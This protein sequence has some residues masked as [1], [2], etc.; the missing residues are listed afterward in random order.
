[1]DD[2][3]QLGS[4]FLGM[5]IMALGAGKIQEKMPAGSPNMMGG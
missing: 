2:T 5:N 1:M 3:L 4:G